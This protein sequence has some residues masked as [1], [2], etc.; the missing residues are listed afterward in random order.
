MREV[1]GGHYANAFSA[2]PPGQMF[3]VEIAARRSR[4]LRM[5]VQIDVKAH[6]SDRN[7]DSF[8]EIA[9]VRNTSRVSSGHGACLCLIVFCNAAGPRVRCTVPEADHVLS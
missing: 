1:A 8:A 9:A 4:V 7:G 6:V 3:E 5:D 2:R